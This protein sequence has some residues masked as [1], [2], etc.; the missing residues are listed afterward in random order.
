MR[1]DYTVRLLNKGALPQSYGLEV[2]GLTDPK[3]HVAGIDT[4]ANG[5]LTV[6][7]GPDQTRE[8]RFS[9]RVDAAQ[10]PAKT[11]DITVRATDLATGQTAETKDHF[12][13]Q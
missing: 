2:T 12:V 7:V 8:L 5:K 11:A 9:I 1:N 13:V 6:E 10:L 3:L 4:G